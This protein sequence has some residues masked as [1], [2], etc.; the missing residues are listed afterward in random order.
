[1]TKSTGEQDDRKIGSNREREGYTPPSVES[2]AHRKNAADLLVILNQMCADDGE[3]PFDLEEIIGTNPEMVAGEL[4]AWQGTAIQDVMRGV[5]ENS[6]QL[7]QTPITADFSREMVEMIENLSPS[8]GLGVEQAK[9]KESWVDQVFLALSSFFDLRMVGGAVA[10]AGVASLAVMI[11]S[12]ESQEQR[13]QQ[14]FAMLESSGASLDVNFPDL[15][16][17]ERS[18]GND[19]IF[20]FSSPT[21]R[22]AEDADRSMQRQLEAL[23]G[24]REGSDEDVG[25]IDGALNKL[26]P[27]FGAATKNAQRD[28]AIDGT[29]I[30][31][32]IRAT[33]RDLEGGS[34]QSETCF[35]Y[36]A[37][38]RPPSVFANEYSVGFLAFCPFRWD[39]KLL[40]LR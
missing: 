12:G 14:R 39:N 26:A 37:V 25:D 29:E 19:D 40:V 2:Q 7:A 38:R 36:E 5:R 8:V 11:S 16:A 35:I 21:M 10:F 18:A 20:R 32:K 6:S 22:G 23:F 1:M 31:F 24:S 17:V 9:K 13:W 4:A 30:D 3:P 28:I 15:L 33:F 34:D 27:V